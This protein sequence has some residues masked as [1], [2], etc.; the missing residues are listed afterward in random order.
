MVMVLAGCI[1]AVALLPETQVFLS[2]SRTAEVT[3]SIRE[4]GLFYPVS[5]ILSFAARLLSNNLI[6]VGNHFRGPKNYYECAILSVSILFVFSFVYLMHRKCWKKVLGI[7]VVSVILL[8]MPLTSQIIN[9]STIRQ[10]WTFILCF[11]QIIAIGYALTDLQNLGEEKAQKYLFPTV[12]IS[13]VLLAAAAAVFLCQEIRVGDWLDRKACITLVCIVA[14]YHAAFFV[15]WKDKKKHWNILLAVVA[16]ELV[17]ANYATVNNRG[18]ISIA[19]WKEEM[20]TDGTSEV[21]QWIT[22]EDDSLYRINK[23]YLSAYYTDSLIQGYNG[24]GTYS[25]TN[26]A[27][28]LNL[29]HSFGYDY[30]ENWFG[31]DGEDLLANTMLGVKYII[32]EN[33]AIMNPD[34]YEFV[35]QTDKFSVYQNRFWLGFGYWYPVENVQTKE[36]CGTTLE[37]IVRLSQS[38]YMAQPEESATEETVQGIK[39]VDLLPLL[40]KYSECKGTLTDV[41][42]LSGTGADMLL[43][44][45]IPDLGG[46][47]LVS[48]VKVKMTAQAPA[49]MSL[50]VATDSYAFTT[51]RYDY[52]FYPSDSGC[53]YLDNTTLDEITEIRLDISD[54]AQEICVESVELILVDEK[55]L[56]EKLETLQ[57][58]SVTDFYQEGNAFYAT[59]Q[60]TEK[61][62]EMLCIPLVYAEQWQATVDGQSV[63]IENIN[64][65][66]VGLR[67]APGEHEI[68]IEYIDRT[69]RLGLELTIFGVGVYCMI[70]LL[71]KYAIKKKQST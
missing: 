11:A 54:I 59:V 10:R 29:V 24:M 47:W 61:S 9:F 68:R 32:S 66:L 71:S 25:S 41:L 69:G 37:K 44:F 43:F 34:Y 15:L 26:S 60:N 4:E 20:Y 49:R 50:Y 31:F 3:A 70:L 19:Q 45:D 38:Y 17:L 33:D 51:E 56:K 21:V 67:L 2:S 7:T 36:N 65:G 28:V 6:G 18:T 53:Y 62:E 64:G 14:V 46:N 63:R 55:I 22:S 27:E 16:V 13:D 52:L 48:G 40:T 57:E 5:V 23:T 58:N 30:A 8:C 39:T 42:Q 12:V 35:Y 1:S